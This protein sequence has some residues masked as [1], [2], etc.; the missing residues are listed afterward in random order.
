MSGGGSTGANVVSSNI[1][2]VYC[3]GVSPHFFRQ[4]RLEKNAG[5]TPTQSGYYFYRGTEK[6]T[7]P[8]RA[9]SN[10]R[11]CFWN[12]ALSANDISPRASSAWNLAESLSSPTLAHSVCHCNGPSR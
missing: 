2:V 12:S 4:H 6:A 10:S 9:V 11:N 8:A 5:L 1:S 7:P 3:V